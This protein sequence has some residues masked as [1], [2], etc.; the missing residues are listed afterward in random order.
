[1]E[2]QR[3]DPKRL[4]KYI[5]Y[6]IWYIVNLVHSIS[7]YHGTYYIN[8]SILQAMV[9]GIPP[10][11]GPW[12]P[13]CGILVCMRSVGALAERRR[14]RRRIQ[15][16]S[17]GASYQRLSYRDPLRVSHGPCQVVRLWGGGAWMPVWDSEDS[18]V[19]GTSFFEHAQSTLQQWLVSSFCVILVLCL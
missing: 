2:P 6:S 14:R 3:Q 15:A 7:T 5:A 19:G 8:M 9:S 16:D 13:K 11:P 1:M 12:N 18:E 17:G 10:C 4:H